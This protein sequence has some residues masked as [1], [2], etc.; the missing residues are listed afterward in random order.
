MIKYLIIIIVILLA[1]ISLLIWGFDSP[2]YLEFDSPYYDM[3]L[4]DDVFP[5]LEV[6]DVG[7]TDAELFHIHFLYPTRWYGV[8]VSENSGNHLVV[9]ENE[10]YS[11]QVIEIWTRETEPE[12]VNFLPQNSN[13]ID[14]LEIETAHH[15][16]E[17]YI[18]DIS[19]TDKNGNASTRWQ[20]D[21]G[22]K[23]VNIRSKDYKSGD[24]LY[25]GITFYQLRTNADLDTIKRFLVN[26]ISWPKS[27][28]Y[29][30]SN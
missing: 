1:V 13:L 8:R 21:P 10:D 3:P 20:L 15:N 17:I 22:Y 23:I 26:F 29:Y 12:A 4:G 7:Y 27:A 16:A 19:D 25:G 24:I 30:V 2:N 18:Y 14:K 6:G 9:R 11:G 28:A 5:Y